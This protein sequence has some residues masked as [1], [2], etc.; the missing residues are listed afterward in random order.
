VKHRALEGA[1]HLYFNYGDTGWHVA[2]ANQ[3][4]TALLSSAKL[5]RNTSLI[6]KPRLP[7]RGPLHVLH[8]SASLPC[9]VDHKQLKRND[10][11]IRLSQ[12]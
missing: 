12:A 10:A 5:P 11:L 6:L 4:S 1:S 2:E 7:H 3:I 8:T 9:S